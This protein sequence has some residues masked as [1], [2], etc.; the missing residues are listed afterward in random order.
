MISCPIDFTESNLSDTDTCIMHLL[1][2]NFIVYSV[3]RAAQT[4]FTVSHKKYKIIRI[5]QL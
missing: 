3:L 4:D 5:K 2:L 1:T